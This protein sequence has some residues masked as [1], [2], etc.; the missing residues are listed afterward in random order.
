[1][2]DDR[3]K[4]VV[5]DK[6]DFALMRQGM[7]HLL[8]NFAEIEPTFRSATGFGIERTRDLYALLEEE[9]ERP[10]APSLRLG[11]RDM[12][13]LEHALWWAFYDE[14][15]AESVFPAEEALDAFH[16]RLDALND[17]HFRSVAIH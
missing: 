6:D 10:D 4:K 15:F 2:V 1:V 5:F 11:W 3:V 7:R 16:E 17:R 9:P 12:A 14:D 8:D 13:D